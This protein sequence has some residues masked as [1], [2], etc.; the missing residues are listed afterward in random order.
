MV[1]RITT[2]TE[3]NYCVF[4]EVSKPRVYHAFGDVIT[5]M[6]RRRRAKEDSRDKCHGS[7][8]KANWMQT[9][10]KST[11]LASLARSR[12]FSLALDIILCLARVCMQPLRH[13]RWLSWR[14]TIFLITMLIAVITSRIMV[15][16]CDRKDRPRAFVLTR[17]QRARS[18]YFFWYNCTRA[19]L[20]R[21]DTLTRWFL[22]SR[23][24][25]ARLLVTI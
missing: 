25:R 17:H 18:L 21:W 6:Q 3:R 24:V 4:R 5:P 13:S 16:R 8:I 10:L 2:K 12:S 15:M 20:S 22:I 1:Y 11:A 23:I 14:M 19:S 7:L 9:R